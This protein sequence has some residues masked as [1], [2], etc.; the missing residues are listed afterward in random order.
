MGKKKGGKTAAPSGC[1]IARSGTY[2]SLSWKIAA[3]NSS[4]GQQARYTVDGSSWGGLSVG[5]TATSVGGYFNPSSYV[6]MQV[7]D[8]QGGKKGWSDWAGATFYIYTPPD[9]TCSMS[10]DENYWN[11]CNI[12]WGHAGDAF[13]GA[14]NY[15]YIGTQRATT[16]HDEKHGDSWS[17]D[18]IGESGSFSKQEDSLVLSSGLG[19]VRKYAFRTYGYHGY[20]NWVY[21]SHYYS[22]PFAPTVKSAT[23]SK[24]ETGGINCSLTWNS[25]S[26][27]YH[28]IDYTT[29]QYGIAVPGPGMSCP[30][31]ISWTERPTMLDTP[32]GKDDGDSFYIDSTM[33]YDNCLFVRVIN[34]HDHNKS[35]SVPV[36]A[37]GIITP[38]SEPSGFSINPI[39]ETYRVEVTVDNNSAV[40]D[41]NI[42][43][44]Y[45]SITNGVSNEQIIAIIPN[46]VT[47]ATIQCPNFDIPDEW[48]LGVFAFVGDYGSYIPTQDA[49]I[50]A[51]TQPTEGTW[52]NGE[53]W[54]LRTGYYPD[55]I[56]TEQTGNELDSSKTYYIPGTVVSGKT[57]YTRTGNEEQTATPIEE[58]TGNPHENGYYEQYGDEYFISDD[59]TVIEGK[60]YYTLSE[61]VPYEYTT[62]LN[63]VAADLPLY[64]ELSP[65]V[66]K[67]ISYDVGTETYVYSVYEVPNI[68]MKSQTVWQGGDVPRAPTNVV[69]ICPREGVA[70]VTWDWAWKSAD[71][72]ELSWSDHD[73][74]WESTDQPETYRITNAHAGKWSIY[75]LD[76]GTTWYIRVRLIKTTDGGENPGPWSDISTQSSLDMASAPNAPILTCSRKSVTHDDSF[77]VSWEYESTDG[78]DQKDAILK[79]ATLHSDGTVTYGDDIR[80]NIGTSRSLDLIPDDLGWETGNKYGFVLKVISE[81]EKTSPWS[82]P[83]YISVAEPLLCSITSTSLSQSGFYI[84]TADTIL[85]ETKTYY[86]LTGT[87]VAEPVIS[88]ISNYYELSDGTYSRTNDGVIDETKTYYTVV[89]TE[90]T[91]PDVSSIGTYYE[92]FS[93]NVLRRMPLSL[94]AVISGGIDN[95]RYT[96]ISI[97]RASSYFVDRPDE[98]TYSG[99]EGETIYSSSIEDA[100]NIVINQSDLISNLD[101]TAHYRISI[102]TYD[103]LDQTAEDSV[104]FYV[105]WE[106]QAAVPE[107]T[108]EFD[109]TY[110][111]MKITPSI[112][113][114]KYEEGDTFDIYR[115]SVDKPVLIVKG[116]HF[117]ETYV[118]PYPTI[119]PYGGHR[120]VTVTANGDFISNDEESDMAWTDLD[121]EEGDIF[122]SDF[123][124]V[125]FGEGSFQILYNVDLSTNWT[126]DFRETRYLGGHIQGDWNAGIH[127]DS[128]INSVILREDDEE[129]AIMFRRMAEYPGLCH[130]RTLDGSNYYADVQ[131]SESIPHD[132]TPTNSY[133]FKITRVDSDGYDGIELSEW[134]RIIGG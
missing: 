93:W 113:Q 76:S 38:L 25:P 100:S 2:F 85:D 120:V 129:T 117:G 68:K 73:D 124:I 29:V 107:A 41:S 44:V 102:V 52:N 134:N 18:N 14:D 110:S 82:E 32:G 47:S 20:G 121:Y 75:G 58:P 98:T 5:K 43:V 22:I 89:G 91:N 57:Y 69:A 48:S 4:D 55:Y 63:P 125:N 40:P 90:V 62:V 87:A 7:R 86:T 17:Y 56:F 71:I 51:E 118:D 10:L 132:E 128:T 116:G 133:S 92:Y 111:V 96:N 77:T 11:R 72:A 30:S 106:H 66:S 83:E 95:Q 79:S 1:S 78:T 31:S 15:M 42:A 65:S 21:C 39:F 46:G 24:S 123:P 35:Y 64:F 49:Y 12:S 60:T 99:Y 81:S 23:I 122:M 9:A 19:Y 67:D 34:T 130:I 45:R 84:L 131:I 27:E 109:S 126:K 119:G 36:M 3:K 101:D 53:G 127:R 8:N 26:N 103:D 94:S 108:V 33:D 50:V 88:D 114:E 104:E 112:D 37:T 28:P 80:T 61:I 59:T 97:E 70:L 115:L 16:F 6:T 13:T 74:A 105:D 54:Y